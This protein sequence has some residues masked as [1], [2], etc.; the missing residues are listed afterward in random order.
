MT[1]D[2]G[3]EGAKER[4]RDEE[5][6]NKKKKTREAERKNIL[7]ENGKGATLQCNWITKFPCP[8]SHSSILK[9]FSLNRFQLV[10]THQ[11]LCSQETTDASCP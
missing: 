2:S 9:S 6:G 8:K 3:K 4:R 11:H 7:N 5:A 10:L 1:G